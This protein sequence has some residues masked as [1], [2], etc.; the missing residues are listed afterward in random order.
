MSSK[1]PNNAMPRRH[2]KFTPDAK[3]AAT[4]GRAGRPGRPGR[5]D[6][7]PKAKFNQLTPYLLEHKGALALAVILSLIGAGASLAQPM[8]VGQVIT[9][10]KNHDDLSGIIWALI[11][12]TLGSAVAG[13]FMYYVLAKAGEGVVLDLDYW[14]LMPRRGPAA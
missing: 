6:S 2:A 14:V 9:A 4:K 1:R 11:A 7:G 12:I 13:G 10:V 8:V 5:P 3:D